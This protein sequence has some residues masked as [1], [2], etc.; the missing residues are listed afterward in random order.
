MYNHQ[1][2]I[3][4]QLNFESVTNGEHR[5]A[6]SREFQTTELTYFIFLNSSGDVVMPSA[7]TV[8]FQVCV[9]GSNWKTVDGGKF[10]AAS[11][12]AFPPFHI[13]Q[14]V[15]GRIIFTGIAGAVA[16]RASVRMSDGPTQQARDLLTSSNRGTRRVRVDVGQ[17]SFF[18]G[19]EFRTFVRLNIPQGQ[20]L[21]MCFTC[22]VNFILH[23]ERLVVN[24]GEADHTAY[25]V[26]SDITGTWTPRPAIGR[27]IMTDRPTPPYAAQGALEYGGS[28]S[29]NPTDEVGPPM[30][31]KTSG[32]T[33]QQSTVPSGNSRERG[34]A[35]GT[36]YLKLTAVSGPLVG[37]YYLDWEERP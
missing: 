14:A 26:V 35:P 32:A 7:G 31:P 34:L 21:Y 36:Y 33:A 25:R 20:S 6:L 19:R 18:E 17:T 3:D 23:D 16:A 8:E 12:F 30:I 15:G 4:S 13:G 1:N 29:V 10:N 28:F 27:N 5:F 22:P 9:D 11:G 2:A 24:S 37:V